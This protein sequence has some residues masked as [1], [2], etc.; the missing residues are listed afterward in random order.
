MAAA[1]GSM[2]T[3]EATIGAGKGTI[4]RAP[5]I[6]DPFWRS[7]YHTKHYLV[8]TAHRLGVWAQVHV[9]FLALV[10]RVGSGLVIVALWAGRV[11]DDFGRRVGGLAVGDDGAAE[12]EAKGVGDDGS[13][14]RGDAAASDQLDDI[15]E[16]AV[17]TFRGVVGAILLCENFLEEVR[18]VIQGVGESAGAIGVAAAE[19]A[20]GCCARRRQRLPLRLRAWQRV[21]VRWDDGVDSADDC[22]VG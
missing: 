3:A 8:S 6:A 10:R 9:R 17:D 21:A 7:L 12:H 13:A 4:Y 16:D 2:G 5:T 20:P 11:P 18:K 19:G 1:T 22:W 14:A 15:R